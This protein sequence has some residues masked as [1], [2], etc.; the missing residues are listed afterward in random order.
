MALIGR[1]PLNMSHARIPVTNISLSLRSATAGDLLAPTTRLKLGERAWRVTEPSE[2]N[3][4]P[5]VIKQ[6][7][8]TRAFR[9][10]L[11]LTYFT[12]LS[13]FSGI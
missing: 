6:I 10:A 3:R 2:W 12:S 8:D 11:K 13:G 9:R 1:A 7:R 5:A 4:L